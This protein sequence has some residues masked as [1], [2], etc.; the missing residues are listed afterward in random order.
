[1]SFP[2][3][4]TAHQYSEPSFYRGGIS[5]E[6]EPFGRFFGCSDCRGNLKLIRSLF[7]VVVL[8]KSDYDHSRKEI[9]IFSRR[10]VPSDNI[11]RSGFFV[12]F[13]DDDDLLCS[14]AAGSPIGGLFIKPN[15]ILVDQDRISNRS[16]RMNKIL[17]FPGLQ[18]FVCP[19]P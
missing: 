2:L 13:P 7:L 8:S 12:S 11:N 15:R 5:Q 1:M 16:Q 10:S 3:S 18:L 17:S 14:P 9:I 6:I 4:S 19:H